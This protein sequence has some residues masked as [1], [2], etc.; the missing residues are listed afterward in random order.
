MAIITESQVY[1]DCD[2]CGEY[3]ATQTMTQKKLCVF[4][5]TKAGPLEKLSNARSVV[6]RKRYILN[7]WK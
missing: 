6:G 3:Y 1:V 4:F 7:G 2:C 5:G